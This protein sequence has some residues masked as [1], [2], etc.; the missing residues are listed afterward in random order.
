[1]QI[2]QFVFELFKWLPGV[3]D[4]QSNSYTQVITIPS[5]RLFQ[6]RFAVRLFQ[7]RFAVKMLS[8][9]V[10]IDMRC[11]FPECSLEAIGI[12]TIFRGRPLTPTVRAGKGMGDKVKVG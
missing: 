3:T 1:M 7:R 4:R 9:L 8:E 2:G 11:R 5:K 10:N 12:S 6:R